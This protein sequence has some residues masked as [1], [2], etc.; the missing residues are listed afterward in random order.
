MNSDYEEF[1][2]YIF[3]EHIRPRLRRMGHWMHFRQDA[4][5]EIDRL[6]KSMRTLRLIKDY[7]ESDDDISRTFTPE[8][9]N[10]TLENIYHGVRFN[11]R[12]V[13]DTEIADIIQDYFGEI[14]DGMSVDHFPNEDFEV[15]Q[16]SGSPNPRRE[17]TAIVHLIKSR[18][19]QFIR[20]GDNVRFSRRLVQTSERIEKIWKSFPV[21][22]PQSGE[23][24]S[25]AIK[26]ATF[27]GIGSIVQGALITATD[28]SLAAG[29]WSV[30]LP[31]ETT[32][33]GAV[34]SATS[35]IG[36]I[37]TGIGELRGE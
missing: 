26:R 14:V 22:P 31:P 8:M 12:L 21:E 35:G 2:K 32:S 19:E 23:P 29:W 37:L 9:L 17:V 16:Q 20:G 28:I 6:S 4:E 27:K 7:T 24:S 36:M 1:I 5:Y 10:R 15:L 11:N 25:P 30:P 33:V 3:D 18:K 13:A 34:V